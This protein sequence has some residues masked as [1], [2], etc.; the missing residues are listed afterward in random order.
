MNHSLKYAVPNCFFT[1][2]NL[3]LF[4]PKCIEPIKRRWIIVRRLIEKIFKWKNIWTL[5]WEYLS[6]T[7][8]KVVNYVDDNELP[9]DPE[10]YAP[11]FDDLRGIQFTTAPSLLALDDPEP[12]TYR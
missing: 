6:W 11:A 10:D 1:L 8:R 7:V 4:Y 9:E 12:T 3:I 5:C 2:G